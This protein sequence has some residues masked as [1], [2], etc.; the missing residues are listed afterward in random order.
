MHFNSFSCECGLVRQPSV[1]QLPEGRCVCNFPIVTEGLKE[2][3]FFNCSFFTT[4]RRGDL[5]ENLKPG[6]RLLLT[7]RLEPEMYKEKISL[8]YNIYDFQI[9]YSMKKTEGESTPSNKTSDDDGPDAP[10]DDDMNYAF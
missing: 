5:L 4:T 7:G 8:K 1:K 3:T 6:T 9:I 2:K 10:T